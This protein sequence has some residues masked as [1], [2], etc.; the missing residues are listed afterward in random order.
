[1]LCAR[2]LPAA[3]DDAYWSVPAV[4]SSCGMAAAA[5]AGKAAGENTSAIDAS[6]AETLN[7][8]IGMVSSFLSGQPV[9]P[10]PPTPA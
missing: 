4:Q 2:R 1:M 6:T 3:R 7:S 8:A 5:A 9:V 10:P